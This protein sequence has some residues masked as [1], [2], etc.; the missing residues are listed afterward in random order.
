MSGVAEL[1]E[2]AQA[3]KSG[4]NAAVRQADLEAQRLEAEAGRLE[5]EEEGRRIVA[6]HRAQIQKLTREAKPLKAALQALAGELAQAQE[7]AMRQTARMTAVA[8]KRQ[9]LEAE[10]DRL[11]A[12]V[13][14][15]LESFGRVTQELLQLIYLEP[16][17][18]PAIAEAERRVQTLREQQS[19]L[20][21]GLK[22][23]Q[24][25]IAGRQQEAD[26]PFGEKQKQ[27]QRRR[28]A[29]EDRRE[30]QRAVDAFNAEQEEGHVLQQGAD[31]QWY[32]PRASLASNGTIRYHLLSA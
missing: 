27:E 30:K 1:R 2:K 8:S 28:R 5:H 23:L 18:P 15:P 11:L 12:D 17:F 22:D 16:F 19:Q 9:E 14:V 6:G 20:G 7:R 26:D 10:R 4:A 3:L 31:G 25:Q 13:S 29:E 24:R 21:G 32:R